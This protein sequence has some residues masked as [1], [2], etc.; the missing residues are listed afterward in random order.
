MS[1]QQ[2][3]DVPVT[4]VQAGLASAAAAASGPEEGED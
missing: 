2:E 1:E 3:Q 4:V